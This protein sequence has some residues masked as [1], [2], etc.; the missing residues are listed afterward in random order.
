MMMKVRVDRERKRSIA[1]SF[2]SFCST[3]S[4]GR[5]LE[6]PSMSHIIMMMVLLLL[7]FFRKGFSEREREREN[8]LLLMLLY[9]VPE[10]P[11]GPMDDGLEG[12]GGSRLLLEILLRES[13]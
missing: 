1:R 12:R 3:I 9:S 8:F 6:E 2:S 10:I 11:F 4:D 5:S 13:Q 7:T